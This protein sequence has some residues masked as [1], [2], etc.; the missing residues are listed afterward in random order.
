MKRGEETRERVARAALQLFV[1]KGVGETTVRDIAAAAGVA[2]GSLYRHYES[3]EALAWDLFAGAFTELAAELERLQKVE[4][5]VRAKIAAM[6]RHFC[7]FFDRDRTLF[8]Y[9]LLS[10]HGQLRRVTEEMPQPAE[11]LRR[12]IHSA[13]RRGEVPKGDADLATSM[14]MGLVLQV[15]VDRIYGRV[16]HD[17]SRLADGLTAAAWRVLEA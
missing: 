2:E 1:E 7:A 10:Q 14:V 11:V 9:L 15:A 8:S 13:M 17:L 6:V 12:V 3:K 4:R 16:R 5:T